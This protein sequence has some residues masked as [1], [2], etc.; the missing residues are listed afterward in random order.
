MGN[1][2]QSALILAA[3]LGSRIRGTHDL[4]KGFLKPGEQ[5]L[6]ERSLC[7]LQKYGIAEIHLVTGYGQSHYEELKKHYRF[8]TSHNADYAVTGS[9]YSY[10]V[11]SEFIVPPFLLLESDILYEER[12]LHILQESTTENAILLSGPT[13]SGDEVYVA[14]KEG[15]IQAISKDRRMVPH[16]VGELTGLS[17]IGEETHAALLAYSRRVFPGGKAEHYETDALNRIAPSFPLHYVLAQD[18]VWC[19]IDDTAHLERARTKILP[20]LRFKE[21]TT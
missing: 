4:P 18:L 16:P 14:G 13:H 17:L 21:K 2:A 7:L 19:E 3:G 5:T 10:M 9:L 1:A 12:A 6:I 20:A 8:R 11:A 15:R